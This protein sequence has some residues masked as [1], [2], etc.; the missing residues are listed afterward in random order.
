MVD[1]ISFQNADDRFS[2]TA[3]AK[4]RFDV[5]RGELFVVAPDPGRRKRVPLWV[6]QLF[7]RS[8][9]VALA[10]KSSVGRFG[11]MINESKSS[12]EESQPSPAANAAE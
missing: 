3:P 8:E 12:E 2:E 6:G 9:V 4:D 7:G 1:N 5:E 10:S 11:S